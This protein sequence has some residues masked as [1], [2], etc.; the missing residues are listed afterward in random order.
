MMRS[1]QWARR[2]LH[3]RSTRLPDDPSI[4]AALAFDMA[5]VRQRIMLSWEDRHR[6]A[7]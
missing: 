3:M 2:I 7:E 6:Y 1:Y 4:E 5:G